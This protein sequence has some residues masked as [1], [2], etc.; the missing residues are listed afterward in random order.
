MYPPTKV[1]K[2]PS[3]KKV[4]TKV[5]ALLYPASAY[6]VRARCPRRDGV[7]PWA[8]CWCRCRARRECGARGPPCRAVSPRP[9]LTCG[10][11]RVVVLTLSMVL[12]AVALVAMSSSDSASEPVCLP[13]PSM[14]CRRGAREGA[15]CA[16]RRRRNRACL[17]WSCS[18]RWRAAAGRAARSV[19][20]L[21]CH[22]PPA[23]MPAARTVSSL[24]QEPGISL[25]IRYAQRVRCGA[26]MQHRGRE[27]GRKE[28]ESE[29]PKG[30][31]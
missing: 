10:L 30:W 9:P 15:P 17:R 28:G 12:A 14:S 25:G 4:P 29:M 13:P 7:A 20:C 5:S 22:L 16:A 1:T 19:P 8:V 26:A 21:T 23:Q 2:V 11:C 18:G 3:R 31:G 27:R 24:F 6:A